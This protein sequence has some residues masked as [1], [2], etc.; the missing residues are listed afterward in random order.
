QE[1]YTPVK[2]CP[3]EDGVNGVLS[4]LTQRFVESKQESSFHRV[5]ETIPLLMMSAFFAAR[6]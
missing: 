1:K 4:V 3:G 5:Q 2:A 6:K